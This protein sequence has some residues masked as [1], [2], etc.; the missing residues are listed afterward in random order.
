MPPNPRRPRP[1]LAALAAAVV[2][3]L[4]AG[5]A[6]A[7]RVAE[8]PAQ[9]RD[10]WTVA[11]MLAAEPVEGVAPAAPRAD[12]TPVVGGAPS[13]V[14]ASGDGDGSPARLRDGAPRRAPVP[15]LIARP[16]PDP[17]ASGVRMH[18]RVFFTVGTGEDADDYS[19]S[20]TA[21][22][23][24][25]R[26]AVWTAAHC[27]FDR[28]RGGYVTNWTFVPAYED[29]AAPF[30]EWPARR[31]LATTRYRATED[32][33]YDFGAAAVARNPSGQALQ[34]V[35]GARGIA[36]G[37]PRDQRYVAYGYPVTGLFTGNRREFRCT[38]DERGGDRF[39]PADPRPLAISCDM[40][41]GASGGGWVAPGGVVLSVT[42]YGY[43]NDPFT[44]Y[45]PYLGAAA[46]SVYRDIAKKR[47]PQRGGKKGKGG[48]RGGKK[49]GRSG[50]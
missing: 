21:V 35:V 8:R 7:E 4:A 28:R 47:K 37:Q 18:G 31:L 3:L 11:R 17:A 25:N 41:G 1:L 14:P 33:R 38:S 26:R 2:A 13:W 39:Y 5:P 40:T 12:A 23:S 24:G 50:P 22:N 45:G 34:D 43:I 27:I 6:A 36:F 49:D 44:L 16:V 29:G 48:K 9:V 30:G 46:E 32:L 20:G 10:Y 15:A 42:S 19:C